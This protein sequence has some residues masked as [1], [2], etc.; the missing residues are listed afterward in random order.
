MEGQLKKG[1]K[2]SARDNFLRASSY[3]CSADFFLHGNPKDPRIKHAYERSTACYKA[4]AALF[5]P[6]IEPVEIPYEGTTLQGYFHPA[7]SSGKP[8]PTLLL[9]NG[10]DG[11][12]EEMHWSGARAAVERGYNVLVFDGPGQ[13]SSVHRQG[14]HFRHDW[15]NVVTPVVNYALTR[16]LLFD[17]C[18]PGFGWG[19][20]LSGL[21]SLSDEFTDIEIK[22]IK[23]SHFFVKMAYICFLNV[24]FFL[25]L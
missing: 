23:L 24:A 25:K 11:S 5:T 14:L 13:Y 16:P 10:F 8:R 2:I 20:N 18:S 19:T 17:V 1:H 9:N 12:P 15:E 6:A 7:D 22:G 21:E 3:Y 4:A